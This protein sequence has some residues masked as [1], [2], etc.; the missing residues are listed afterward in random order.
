MCVI[1][2]VCVYVICCTVHDMPDMY[3]TLLIR[4]TCNDYDF[5]SPEKTPGGTLRNTIGGG[6]GSNASC[7]LRIVTFDL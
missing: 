1:L 7:K 3:S 6:C 5:W 2:I 4:V